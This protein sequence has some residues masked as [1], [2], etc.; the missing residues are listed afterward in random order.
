MHSGGHDEA[1]RKSGTSGVAQEKAAMASVHQKFSG[2]KLSIAKI[3]A[4][5][6]AWAHKYTVTQAVHKTSMD[7]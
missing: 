6:H 2:S 1:H 4:L 3:L 7:N 5:A